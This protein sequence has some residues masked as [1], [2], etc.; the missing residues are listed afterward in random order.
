MINGIISESLEYHLLFNYR[1][2]LS[3]NYI[4]RVLNILLHKNQVVKM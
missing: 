3:S 4:K 1:I 2:V